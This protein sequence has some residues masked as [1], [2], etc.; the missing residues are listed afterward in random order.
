MDHAYIEEH[1]IADRYVLGTLPADEADRFED[2]YLS[3]PECLDRLNLAESVERGFKRMAGEE[4]ARLTAVRQLAL[5]AWLARLGRQR[6]I[7]L[8]LGAFL[9]LAVLPDGLAL[10]GIAGRER[11]LAEVRSVL[12]EERQRSAAGERSAAEV[13]RL[14]SELNAN[15]HDLA[16]ERAARARAAE[17]LAQAQ[18]P[19]VNVPIVFLDAERDAGPSSEPTQRLRQ[20]AAGSVVF[21]LPVDSPFRPSYRAVLRDRH[22]RELWRGTDLKRNEHDTLSWSLPASL[23]PPGDYSFSIEGMTQ[24]GKPTAAGR[25]TF[26]VLPPA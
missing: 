9:V 21:S 5:V 4:A 16:G 7:T 20:P 17:Q 3:C 11:D 22:G 2:H 13:A 23:V 15:R 10:R 24:G 26:R 14:R 25:I 19:Q 8:L 18:K 1:Q 12:K 6:Q